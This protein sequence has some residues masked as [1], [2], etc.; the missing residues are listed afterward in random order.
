METGCGVFPS[1]PCGAAHAAAPASKDDIP[2]DDQSI[3]RLFYLALR[4]YYRVPE[5]EIAGLKEEG[6]SYEELPVVFFIAERS[7]VETGGSW[8]CG[9]RAKPGRT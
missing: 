8:R 3:I 5:P 4:D 7:Q 1:R 2:K 9:W 6:L